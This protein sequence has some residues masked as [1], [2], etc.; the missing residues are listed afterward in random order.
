MELLWWPFEAHAL[1]PNET[2]LG[3][4]LAVCSA[5]AWAAH[6]LFVRMG[7]EESELGDVVLVAV[8][9]QVLVVVPI[10]V[11]VTRDHG[12]TPETI[13]L[14]AAAGLASGLFG[15]VFQ[16]ASTRRIGASKT[17]PI[18]A[19]AGLVSAILAVV[20]LGESVT[21]SHVLGILL[22][23]VGVAVTSWE[24]A[25][26]GTN[27]WDTA[28]KAF[29]YPFL[30]VLFYG[31]EPILVKVGIERGTPGL[32]GLAVMA[33]VAAATFFAYRRTRGP[34]A[35]NA[36]LAGPGTYWAILAGAVGALA[37]VF[38]VTALSMAPVVIV[39]PLFQTTPVLVAGLSLAFMPRHLER[40]SVRLLAGAAT[41]VVGATLVSLAG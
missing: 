41:V 10:A 3:V 25:I 34:V 22:V 38:Y 19:S 2:V 32:V 31:V 6:Y 28:G 5:L 26:G 23:V 33:V 35:V 1:L 37:Y 39:L 36:I 16:Y 24:T 40:V 7:M 18:V 17:S 20:L 29:V 21:P 14:F 12:L 13:A 9:S 15:R 30:A 27:A 4:G 8:V 11:T